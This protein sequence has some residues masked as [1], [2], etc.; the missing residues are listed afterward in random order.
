VRIGV[1]DN[2]SAA[3]RTFERY[4]RIDRRQWLRTF[5]AGATAAWIAREQSLTAWLAAASATGKAFPVKTVNHVAF[6]VADYVRS[7]DF[8]VDLF[9]MRVV[10]DDGK[11]CALEFGSPT[12]PNGLYFRNV[13]KP[14]D[15]PAVLHFAFGIPNFQAQKAA[16][17]A[18]LDRRGVKNLR[19]DGATG[20]SCDDPAGYPLNVFVVEKDNAMFP[21]AAAPCEDAVSEKCRTA[22]AAGTTNLDALPKPSGKGFRATSYSHIVL[23]VPETDITAERD[24]YRDLLG[25]KVI[26][27]QPAIPTAQLARQVILRFDRNALV[28]QPTP[29]AGEKPY[30]N[31]FGFVVDRYAPGTV[32]AELTRR[33]LSPMADSKLAWTIAD[34]DG[35][36]IEVAGWSLPE[37]M[38]A[39]G[40]R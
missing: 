24:F 31:H 11:N 14:G 18:E 20:W 7:R 38:A 22:Y 39:R 4:Y 10:W 35:F 2:V 28:L 16:M 30:C 33:G 12:A 34:P 27:D 29:Q 37:Q 23:N 15:K 40:V 3:V 8:Y 21:G 6:A 1:H 19:P 13:T 32:E 17:K 9:G 25:M 5:G 26:A 36:R